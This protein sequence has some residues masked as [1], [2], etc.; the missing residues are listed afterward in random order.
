EASQ[1]EG[2]AALAA[3]ALCNSLGHKD[4]SH[5]LGSFLFLHAVN[6]ISDRTVETANPIKDSRC[7]QSGNR[8]SFRH[9]ACLPDS[10][11]TSMILRD[12]VRHRA[13]TP[14]ARRS[15]IALDALLRR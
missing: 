6:S 2:Q 4:S 11:S 12:V 13:D 8:R 5:E 1:K 9:R 15:A 3:A 7:A 14:D 10:V